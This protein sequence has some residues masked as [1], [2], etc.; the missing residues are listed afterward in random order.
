MQSEC[1]QSEFFVTV[2]TQHNFAYIAFHYLLSFFVTNRTLFFFQSAD[3]FICM[4]TVV[5]FVVLRWPT[6]HTIEG[7]AMHAFQRTKHICVTIVADCFLIVP[8]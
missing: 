2:L 3:Q 4:A 8:K 5:F 1:Y 7:A 6:V